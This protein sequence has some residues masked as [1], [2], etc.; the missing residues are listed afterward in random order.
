MLLALT[1]CTCAA[2]PA[3]ELGYLLHKHPARVFESALPFGTARVFYSENSPERSTAALPARL[4]LGAPVKP[5]EAPA[6]NVLPQGRKL[7]PRPQRGPDRPGTGI[8]SALCSH[9]VN[10]PSSTR[11][12][13]GSRSVIG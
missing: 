8:A 6:E 10:V 4:R 13:Q 3:T 5:R 7:C 1:L 11:I 12:P 2:A 9:D